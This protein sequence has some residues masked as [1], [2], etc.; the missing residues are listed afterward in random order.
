MTNILYRTRC[1]LTNRRKILNILLNPLRRI[2]ENPFFDDR[3]LLWELKYCIIYLGLHLIP[4]YNFKDKIECT[5]VQ[6]L[7]IL[8]ENYVF[9]RTKLSVTITSQEVKNSKQRKDL[10]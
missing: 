2:C 10:F 1:L 3:S 5:P 6:F 7:M 8:G 9:K 4:K